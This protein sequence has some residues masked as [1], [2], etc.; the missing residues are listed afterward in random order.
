M[1]IISKF[2]DYYDTAMGF[3]HDD[4]VIFKR[5]T[6]ELEREE[7]DRLT[8]IYDPFIHSYYGK[9]WHDG[10]EFRYDLEL[11]S[12]CIFFCGKAYYGITTPGNDLKVT[13]TTVYDYQSLIDLSDFLKFKVPEPSK[14]TGRWFRRVYNWN[15]G[16]SH[17]YAKSFF[18]GANASKNENALRDLM[19]KER[20]SILV[21][22]KTIVHERYNVHRTNLSVNSPLKPYHFFKVMPPY[23][24]F[25]ELDMWHSGVMAED[26]AM[27]MVQIEDK[28]R[29]PQHG[30]DKWSFRKQGE[31]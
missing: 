30:F 31:K 23:Q 11:Y 29:I 27:K 21:F 3:G 17:H 28:Y 18:E 2:H 7:V 5:E 9:V 10:G 24:A 8:R 1:R 22:T 16:N 19:I 25:Q 14:S 13:P 15:R 4:H 20:H 12:V 26:P 6:P